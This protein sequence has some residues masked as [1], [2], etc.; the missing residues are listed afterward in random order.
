MTTT[1]VRGATG[2]TITIFDVARHA[3]VSITTV[4]HVFSG[5]RPVKEE[6]RR[7]VM[8]AADSLRY[9]PQRTAIAL[10]RG[11]T[12]NLAVYAPTGDSDPV[13]NPF[14]SLL[15]PVMSAAAVAMGY[16]FVLFTS[17]RM[18]E[19]LA[20]ALLAGR[21]VDG[22]ILIDPQR[23]DPF[24]DRLAA[25]DVPFVSLGRILDGPDTPR[26]DIDQRAL[27]REVLDHLAGEGYERPAL[28]TGGSG[29]SYVFD[30]Q[31]TFRRL[32]PGQ[33]VVQ[34]DDRSDRAAYAAAQWL[35][36]AEPRPDAIFCA[37]DQLAVVV[38]RVAAQ[39]GLE[40]PRDLA[41]VG[42][43]DSLARHADPPL[44]SVRKHPEQLGELL[45]SKLDRRLGGGDDEPRVSI[46]AADLVVRQSS[47]RY[48]RSAGAAS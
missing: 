30:L 47:V 1:R 36:K 14:F 21:T 38:L 20:D 29:T 19:N 48:D 39:L 23:G 16:T 24:V 22:V 6:T 46:V 43:G 26:A 31:K 5:K 15:L 37:N 35:L 32:A 44:T 10:A 17:D 45:V 12:M 34:V 13:L 18:T 9:R 40:V 27:C 7:R 41:V 28:F 42:V 4:S 11:R 8:D 2:T 3:G 33:P 25:A